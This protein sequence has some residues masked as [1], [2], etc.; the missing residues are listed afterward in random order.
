M[1]LEKMRPRKSQAQTD[2]PLLNTIRQLSLIQKDEGSVLE[3]HISLRNGWAVAFNGVIA[4]G[5]PIKEDLATC[6]N[7]LLLKEALSKCGQGFSITQNEHNL[8][9]KS[10][11]FKALVP[12]LSLTEL[13]PAFPDN[14]VAQIDDRLKA[15]LEQVVPVALD[16]NFLLT[17][18]VLIHSGT[19]T[20]TDRKVIIQSWHGTDLPPNLVIPRAVIKPLISNPKKLAQFGFSNSSCTF[21]YEDGSWLKTQFFKEQWPDINSILDRKS[22]PLSIPEN[23]YDGVK[24]LEKFSDTGFVYFDSNVMRSHEEDGKGASYQV[25]G[26][27]KGPVLNI[28]QLKMIEPLIKTADFLVPHADHKMTLFFGERVRGAIAGRV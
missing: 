4:M 19:C 21:Y 10:D 14:P 8:L 12:C 28:K 26:L 11:K 27:P 5:E 7:G 2:N 15:S 23:F 9:I 18:S 1:A 6:P 25:Y 16:E 17:A 22:S 20:T 13:Q 3:T 24:S